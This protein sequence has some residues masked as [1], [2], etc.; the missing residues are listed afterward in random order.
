MD[1]EELDNI[2]GR[3]FFLILLVGGMILCLI[4][5]FGDCFNG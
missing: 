5:F 2:A 3:I 4:G 1:Q